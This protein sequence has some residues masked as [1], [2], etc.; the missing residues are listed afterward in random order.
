ME[1]IWKTYEEM[2][3]VI[4][5]SDMETHEL[6]FLNKKCRELFGVESLEQI[7]GEKCYRLLQNNAKPCA[8]CTN[9][10]IKDG[11]I[12]RWEYFN[13]VIKKRFL[14]QDQM[15]VHNGRKI[16]VEIS[17]ALTKEN[18]NHRYHGIDD[19]SVLINE[20]MRMSLQKTDP[21][22][23]IHQMIEY[24]GMTLL[25][26]RVYIFELSEANEWNNTYE[27]CAKNVTAEIDNLQ[28]IPYE[29]TEIWNNEFVQDHF[30]M[31]PEIED[32][33]DS[34]PDVYEYLKPQNIH[35]IIVGPLYQ[36]NHISGFYGID[37]PPREKIEEVASML[38]TIGHVIDSMIEKRNLVRRLE[39]LSYHDQLSNMGN[40]FALEKYLYTVD[41]QKSVGVVY[42]DVTGLKHVN[43]TMGHAA[44]DKL[45]LL[46]C[47]CMKEAFAG[48]ELFRIGGD[49]LLAIGSDISEESFKHNCA[50]LKTLMIE[51]E[52]HLAMG[53]VWE[54]VI[55]VDPKELIEKADA[56]MYTDKRAYYDALH[57]DVMIDSYQG[58]KNNEVTAHEYIDSLTG[59]YTRKGFIR[60]VERIF[61]HEQ[62]EKKYAVI[63]FDVQKFK[64][65]N[66]IFGISGGD[67][68]LRYISQYLMQD[69]KKVR[70]VGHLD[71][72]WFICL[73]E[74]EKLNLND[75]EKTLNFSWTYEGR[76]IRVSLHCGIYFVDDHTIPVNSMIE[77]AILA[78]QST[79]KNTV[80]NFAIFD[81]HMRLD[82][83]SKAEIISS[84]QRGINDEEFKVYLQPIVQLSTN[85]VVS[86]EALVRWQHRHLGFISPGQFIPVLESNGLIT[87]LDHYVLKKVNAYLEQLDERDLPL[88]SVAINLSWQDFYDQKMVD[89]VI[90]IASVHG[91]AKHRINFEVTETSLSAL[92]QNCAYLLKQFQECGS[93]L[94][95]D[96]FGSGVSSLGMIGNYSFDIIKI[97]RSFISQ[98]E[99]N[100]TMR[101]IIRSVIQMS[102]DIGLHVVGEGA[103]T[104][105]E[106]D[107]L[108]DAHCD[109][110][111]GYYFARPMPQEEFDTFVQNHNM[112]EDK[113]TYALANMD[114]P[115]LNE[116]FYKKLLDHINEF[117]MV[118]NPDDYSLIY[119]NA[120]GQKLK[121][122][123]YKGAKCFRKMEGLSQPCVHC[124]MKNIQY[125]TPHNITVGSGDCILDVTASMWEINNRKV[126]VE[127]GGE[128]RKDHGVTDYVAQM[129]TIVEMLPN[130]QMIYH[131]DVTDDILLN[132][133]G[134][135]ELQHPHKK[136]TSMDVLANYIASL[137]KNETAKK[138]LYETL[139][140]A[141]ILQAFENGTYQYSRDYVRNEDLSQPADFR[142]SVNLIRNP[143]TNHIDCL[144]YGVDI[145]SE[146][147]HYATHEETDI[148]NMYQ[149]ADHDRRIDYL[150][151]LRNRLDL[152]EFFNQI[153]QDEASVGTVYMID[154]DN[155]KSINNR[156]GHAF[157]NQCLKQFGEILQ[158]FGKEHGII[159]FRYGGEEALGIDMHNRY[160]SVEVA[161]ELLE[162]FRQ[163]TFETEQG[164]TLKLTISVGYSH[165]EDS[166]KHRIEYADKAV[167]IA[168]KNG[169]NCYASYTSKE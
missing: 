159:F 72:D 146:T 106:V 17:K 108:R 158:N 15:I 112:V 140:R 84:F 132:A 141:S 13:Q 98:I 169:K 50:K 33:R 61:A 14:L 96:D 99:T 7:R 135:S 101:R 3:E 107:F 150:T 117:V 126:F 27:W 93:K 69:R 16:R 82:Y 70:L 52:L 97:D 66:D 87:E 51:N 151:G 5:A 55:D 164:E 62:N 115:V 21:E 110:V 20:C 67:K 65:I 47:A 38:K 85:K 60:E 148:F 46:A 153:E 155:F 8:M 160:R 83:V 39:E 167:Y 42:C 142:V 139:N 109:Y 89:D 157:G 124:V 116:A 71:A 129:K 105:A 10:K 76:T 73:I 49:E 114:Q 123:N 113:A 149:K 64:S 81:E 121:G 75:I 36:D 125:D 86:A 74:R 138:A 91:N 58:D 53:S 25:G 165:Q 54:P 32:I 59:T 104:K 127:I 57:M 37:N 102:H 100:E 143:I 6:V 43:D 122:T 168:K 163:T 35:S 118:I 40:R 90:R 19:M 137:A 162:L 23:G 9:D 152:N 134:K 28:H 111:Q 34:D 128:H 26:Q 119:L 147:K 31:I 92:E 2:D 24:L 12:Y 133:S 56:L 145:L 77:W 144:I 45:L 156:Y 88:F 41:H 136:G 103:E 161:T 22:Q 80:H 29:T 166:L 78:K 120:R 79:N 95:L 94:L 154:I 131:V 68:L 63:A 130:Q 30:I 44:G 1:H 18:E 11:S 48:Y 4:Y